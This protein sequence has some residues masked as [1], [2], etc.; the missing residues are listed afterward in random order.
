MVIVDSHCHL[1]YPQFQER[2]IGNV[3]ADAAAKDVHYA[4]TICT[5]KH[6]AV[7]L[8]ALAAAHPNLFCTFGIH[9]HHAGEE[10]L[11][12]Q[13]IKDFCAPPQVVG[14]GE[15][16]LDYYYTHAPK[17]AQWESFELHLQAAR[18][19]DLPVVIHS[20]DA[21]DDTIAI[22]NNALKEGP[23]K[24]IL[25]CFSSHA[26][27]AEFGVEEGMMVSASGIITFKKSEELRRI[28]REI[29]PL[30][31]MLVET[32]APYLAPMPYRG[33]DN[34]PA[35]TRYVAECIAS[36]KQVPLET[37]AAQTTDNFFNL[38]SKAQRQTL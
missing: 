19:L 15:T 17:Q 22:L 3:L 12:L 13:E 38:F 33:K 21:E 29:V 11:T 20:R 18:V 6:E 5:K 32:D 26:R 37:V 4:L 14:I 8:Q 2:G 28:F 36:E 30:E 34:E 10:A 7:Q 1:N 31:Q 27:L 25:H 9:P 23:L 24:L 35:Y 16:G